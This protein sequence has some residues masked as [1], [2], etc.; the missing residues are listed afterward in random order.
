MTVKTLN[1]VNYRELSYFQH[2]TECLLVNI[3]SELAHYFI[4]TKCELLPSFLKISSI[5]SLLR[6]SGGWDS[7]QNVMALGAGCW[8]PRTTGE[9]CLVPPLLQVLFECL[10]SVTFGLLS[11]QTLLRT[12]DCPFSS[13]I[14]D[15]PS[16]PHHSVMPLICLPSALLGRMSFCHLAPSSR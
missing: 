4:I 14:P 15:P 5:P 6:I 10:D 9:G 3:Q 13:P 16:L 2:K 7:F 12:C 8:F 11:G 1:L